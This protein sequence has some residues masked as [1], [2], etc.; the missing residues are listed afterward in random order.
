MAG[1]SSSS[2]STSRE[3]DQTPTWAVAG[4]CAVM[5]VI[6]IVLEKVLHRV[7]KVSSS[8]HKP[9]QPNWV[10]F[11]SRLYTPLLFSSSSLHL[12]SSLV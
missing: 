11:C 1:D 6:S 12:F 10:L 8:S 5:I 2:S 9:L 3:L 4:I 7:G